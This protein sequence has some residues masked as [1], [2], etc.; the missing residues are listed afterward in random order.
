MI[1]KIQA[2][3]LQT[4]LFFIA[5]IHLYNVVKMTF[6]KHTSLNDHTPCSL[7]FTLSKEIKCSH[8]IQGRQCSKVIFARFF[9]STGDLVASQVHDPIC[10]CLTHGAIVKELSRFENTVA[11][12][13]CLKVLSLLEQKPRAV[14]LFDGQCTQTNVVCRAS[15]ETYF[16]LHTVERQEKC[17]KKKNKKKNR[18]REREGGAR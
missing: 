12:L 6:M 16:L 9:W 14:W 17:K 13:P 15:T 3:H 5:A 10:C 11:L 8:I 1:I 18:L 7:S 2:G 4:L